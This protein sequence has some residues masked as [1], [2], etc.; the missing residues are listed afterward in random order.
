MQGKPKGSRKKTEKKTRVSPREQRKR[1]DIEPGAVTPAEVVASNI[2]SWRRVRNLTQAQLAERMS[3]LD[4]PWLSEGVL[5]FIERGDRTVTVDE[6]LTLALVLGVD[7]PT[8]LDPT[9]IDGTG[10]SRLHVV[11]E[12]DAM[13][14][15][16]AKAWLRG[17]ARV[18]VDDANAFRH[19]PVPG[20]EDAYEEAAPA[21]REWLRARSPDDAPAPSHPDIDRTKTRRERKKDWDVD[22]GQP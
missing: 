2:R 5:G 22:E 4:Y 16:A 19:G 3:A 14:A 7:V 11:K 12:I 18:L 6:L 8:L 21:F 9:G 17:D 20:R 10:T 15:K 1:L 13:P